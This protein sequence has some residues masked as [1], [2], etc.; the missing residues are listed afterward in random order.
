VAA[1]GCSA[2]MACGRTAWRG[3]EI[4]WSWRPDAGAKSSGDDDPEGDGG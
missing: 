1:A 4:A 2:L 3:R